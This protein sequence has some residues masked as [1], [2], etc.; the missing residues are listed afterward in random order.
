VAA[1]LAPGTPS[2]PSGVPA[3]ACWSILNGPKAACRPS[4]PYVQSVL[5]HR[6]H[7]APHGKPLR[8]PRED[9]AESTGGHL[10]RPLLGSRRRRKRIPSHP[11][12][13]QAY[14]SQSRRTP[15]G[16]Q[17]AVIDESA[18]LPG[19]NSGP[20]ARI[21]CDRMTHAVL[22]DSGESPVPVFLR[23]T[24]VAEGHARQSAII[25]G[26]WGVVAVARVEPRSRRS[27]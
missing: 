1:A 16:R 27:W 25:S 3:A 15:R 17:P 8:C 20:S 9:S 22:N 11:W 19:V 4:P 10:R 21:H 14:S 24:K 26:P 12:A 18:R 7:R 23:A 13:L 6:G 5:E 2:A